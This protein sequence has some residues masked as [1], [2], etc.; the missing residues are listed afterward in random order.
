M[1]N[2]RLWVTRMKEV[3]RLRETVDDIKYCKYMESAGQA[4]LSE[5]SDEVKSLLSSYSMHH[6][7]V[8]V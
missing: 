4:L 6:S 8:L 1:I 5:R 3:E 2:Q 7:I